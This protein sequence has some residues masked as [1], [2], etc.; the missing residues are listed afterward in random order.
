MSVIVLPGEEID[1][2]LVIW[3]V[4]LL[5]FMMASRRFVKSGHVAFA[6]GAPDTD[7][8]SSQ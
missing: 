8:R 1:P 7:R 5:P 6:A 4:I 2:K 3:V